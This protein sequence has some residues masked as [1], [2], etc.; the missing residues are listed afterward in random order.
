MK[1]MAKAIAIPFIGFVNVMKEGWNLWKK[2]SN[3]D[4]QSTKQKWYIIWFSLSFCF[5]MICAES[6]LIILA[7]ANFAWSVKVVQENV[8]I[9]EDDE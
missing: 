6:W 7:L 1:K 9:P 3:W 4:N 8:E 5:M 2:T